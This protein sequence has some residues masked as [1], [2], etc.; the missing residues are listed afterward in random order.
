M[1]AGPRR[2]ARHTRKHRLL[3]LGACAVATAGLLAACSGDDTPPTIDYVVDATLSGYNANTV[4]GSA[5]GVLMATTRVLPGFSYIGANGQVT[6]DRDVG[7]VT[8]QP[9]KNLVLRYDFAPR[10]QFSD[11]T[12]LDCDD[13]MLAWAADSGR[14]GGFRPAT[15]AGYRDI[16][17]VDCKPG[18][19]S[20]TVRFAPGRNYQDWAALFGAGTLL[21][22]QVVAR[23][24]GV[25][26][27][28]GAIRDRD[29]KVLDKIADYWNTGFTFT[30]GG[31]DAARFPSSG[32]YR[33]AAYSRADGLVLERNDKW[34]ADPP[35]SGRI[36]LHDRTGDPARRLAD[37]RYDVADT[38]AGLAAAP[39]TG[40]QPSPDKPTR[41]LGVEELVLAQRGVFGDPAVRRAFAS[42]VPRADL[43]RRFG[44]GAPLWNLR[45]LA[46]ADNL[47]AQVNG[48]FGR[49]FERADIG[50]AKQL[51]AQAGQDSRPVRV[52]LGYRAPTDRLRQ[53]TATLAASCR[54]AG[55]DVVDTGSPD[56]EPDD[57]GKQADA[58]LVTDG[59]SFAASGAADPSRDLYQLRTGDPLNVSGFSDPAVDKAVDD[60][61]VQDTQ[62]KRLEAVRTVEGAAWDQMAS[63]PLFADNRDHRTTDAV[64]GVVPGLGRSGTGW[65]MDRWSMR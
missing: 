48:E 37:G 46:P 8:V 55:L 29:A 54:P 19:K 15:T 30:S 59:A 25:P 43:A 52:R 2:R 20:A 51:L 24:A 9:G 63:I 61:V 56:L 21:P 42:C 12:P 38:T 5:D 26:D 7:T 34:W 45:T 23:A 3:A 31:V 62:G 49:G 14:F 4:E 17:S 65:N 13:L 57:L 41:R 18:D 6:P 10:A 44:G 27:V 39:P 36:V 22:A 53:M 1:S 11:G 33:V 35:R 47:A 28:V 60:L 16:E 40:P 58:L 64:A 32:P 50:R